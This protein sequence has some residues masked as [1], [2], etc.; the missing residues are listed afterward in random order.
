[1]PLVE[2]LGILAK[3]DESALSRYAVLWARWREMEDFIDQHGVVYPTRDRDGK[4]AGF[5]LFPQARLAQDLAVQLSRIEAEFGLTPV[6]RARL[7]VE[8]AAAA[9]ETRSELARRFFND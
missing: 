6:A 5:R 8:I 3:V 4:P 7:N 9:V 1:M 2:E